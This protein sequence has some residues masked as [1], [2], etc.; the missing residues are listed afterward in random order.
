MSANSSN[1]SGKNP[2]QS[3]ANNTNTP[4]SPQAPGPEGFYFGGLKK[5]KVSAL[6]VFASSSLDE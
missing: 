5:N 2:D 6:G 4:N 3:K 1:H